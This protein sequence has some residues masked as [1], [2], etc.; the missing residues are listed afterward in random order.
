MIQIVSLQRVFYNAYSMKQN[1][2]YKIYDWILK[3]LIKETILVSYWLI[4]N[5]DWGRGMFGR[6]IYLLGHLRLEKRPQLGTQI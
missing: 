5:K 4:R 3:E 1:P 2:V 6:Q